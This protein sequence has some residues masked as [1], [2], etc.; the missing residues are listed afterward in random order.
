[1]N[2][3]ARGP[4]DRFNA[5]WEPCCNLYVLY[6]KSLLHEYINDENFVS[7]ENNR[8]SWL[9]F[10]RNLSIVPKAHGEVVLLQSSNPF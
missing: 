5:D 3:I 7:V 4:Y 1:M 10:A 6:P 8:S 2:I 9:S